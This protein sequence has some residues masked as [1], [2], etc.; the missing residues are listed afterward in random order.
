M[1]CLSDLDGESSLN[2]MVKEELESLCFNGGSSGVNELNDW[3]EDIGMG[4][5]LVVAE[6]V[7]ESE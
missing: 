6:D 5:L 2:S 1:L 3:T 4:P 7:E